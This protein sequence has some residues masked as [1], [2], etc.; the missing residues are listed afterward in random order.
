MKLFVIRNK[1]ILSVGFRLYFSRR[2]VG[3]ALVE[4]G[5]QLGLD[6]KTQRDVAFIYGVVDHAS[7]FHDQG[8][9]LSVLIVIAISAGITQMLA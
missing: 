2:C 1:I 8:A 7:R 9:Y 6:M 4:D 5:Q 3:K